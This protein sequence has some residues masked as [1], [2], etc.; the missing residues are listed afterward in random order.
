MLGGGAVKWRA[1]IDK[2]RSSGGCRRW[3]VRVRQE[4]RWMLQ[5]VPPD[6]GALTSDNARGG[7][8]HGRRWN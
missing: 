5:K 1:A 3:K 8:V 6:A 7:K 4:R 2:V